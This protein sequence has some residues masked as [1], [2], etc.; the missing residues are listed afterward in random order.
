MKR[1]VL[2]FPGGPTPFYTYRKSLR[3]PRVRM[4]RLCT[5][6]Q[7]QAGVC[8]RTRTLES[9]ALVATRSN[10]RVINGVFTFN[11]RLDNN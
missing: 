4:H 10:C 2:V 6:E 7:S 3:R 5:N 11:E 1:G 8:V 9:F